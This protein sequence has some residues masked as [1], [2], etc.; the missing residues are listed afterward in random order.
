MSSRPKAFLEADAQRATLTPC[1]APPR[2]RREQTPGMMRVDDHRMTWP[3]AIDW[4]ASR[5]LQ[6]AT[7]ASRLVV[8]READ[9]ARS[10][11]GASS[12]EPRRAGVARAVMTARCWYAAGDAQPPIG[13]M[14]R[15]SGYEPDQQHRVDGE[16]RPDT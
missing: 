12:R 4:M 1:W 2:R 8:V 16:H 11:H 7:D 3:S 6:Y 5:R 13:G 9:D 14:T 15:G 10:R